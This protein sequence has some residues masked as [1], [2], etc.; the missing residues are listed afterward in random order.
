MHD[1]QHSWQL[2][3]EDKTLAAANHRDNHTRWLHGTVN[4]HGVLSVHGGEHAMWL[5][6]EDETLATEAE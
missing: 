2:H 5:H 6:G 4:S 1:G 3:E